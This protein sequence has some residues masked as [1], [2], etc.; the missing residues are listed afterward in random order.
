MRF[1]LTLIAACLALTSCSTFQH[2][3][4]P[5]SL[6]HDQIV[7][8]A[9]LTIDPPFQYITFKGDRNPNALPESQ[10]TIEP[11]F[12][13]FWLTLTSSQKLAILNQTTDLGGDAAYANSVEAANTK[14]VMDYAVNKEL[15]V[16][17]ASRAKVLYLMGFN[18][19][20]GSAIARFPANF[21]IQVPEGAKAI[22]IGTF[23]FTRNRF[24]EI[25]G[26]KHVDEYDEALVEFQ[27]KFPGWE[28][29]RAD[30]APTKD[31]AASESPKK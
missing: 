2:S 21:T 16:L 9:K 30:L 1:P 15:M 19:G 24:L 3:V 20:Y 26:F 8:V 5:T 25:T 14:T 12:G 31:L 29:T 18:M 28:L 22:Y 13:I 7:V 23:A 10:G 4:T 27:K 6:K 11:N 17:P